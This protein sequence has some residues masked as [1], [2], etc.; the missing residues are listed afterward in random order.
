MLD[1]N[2]L[3]EQA[4]LSLERLLPR[5]EPLLGQI[6]D[7]DVFFARLEDQFPRLFRLLYQLYGDQYDFFYH[8]EQILRHAATMFT[9]RPEALKALDAQREQNPLWF[10]SENMIGAVCYVD[11]FAGDLE[12][13][14]GR[15]PYFK[16]LGITYL[17]L[18]PLFK[19]PEENNDGGY[20]VSDYRQVQPQLGTMETLSELAAALR[21]EGISLVLDFIFNH[22]SDEHTWAKQALAGDKTYQDYY[23]MFPDRTLPDQYEQTLREIF[24]EQ[25]P[26]SFTFIPEVDKW[27]WTSFYNFQWD[28]NYKNP[29]VFN[30]MLGELLFLAN[31]GV[32]IMRLDA[33]AFIW[34]KMG[35]TCESLPQAHWI[36]Q[37]YNALV[38]IVA[39]ALYFKSEAIVHPDEV[40]SYISWEEAPISYNPTLMA[41]LWESLATRACPSYCAS[42]WP[43]GL[44]CQSLAPGSIMF[45]YMMTSAGPSLMKMLLKFG[46]M[47]MIIGSSSIASILVISLARLRQACRLTSTQEQAICVFQAQRLRWLAWKKR[48]AW[49]MNTLNP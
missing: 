46:S 34:K 48:S 41:L 28:L 42:R 39:P 14:R 36:I 22:T 40:M 1:V 2:W 47:A 31:Q 5:I 8:L 25:A 4:A 30:A 23:Y 9:Q 3:D 32:E 20:A 16:E 12:G 10:Q 38:R 29:A 21:L 49:K 35:T 6:E 11:L 33:V 27:V 43:S 24:P 13:I 18:M 17:H 19:T 26:G 37:A 45:G 44:N 15:I 7:R